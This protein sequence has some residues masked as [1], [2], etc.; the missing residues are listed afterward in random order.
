LLDVEG[1]LFVDKGGV[2]LGSRPVLVVTVRRKD[3]AKTYWFR[4]GMVVN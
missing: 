4:P 3:P 1:A 2:A